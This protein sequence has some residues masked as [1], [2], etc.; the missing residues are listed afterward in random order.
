MSK[1]NRMSGQWMDGEL[2]TALTSDFLSLSSLLVSLC[3]FVRLSLS[4]LFFSTPF[5]SS[6]VFLL[7]NGQNDCV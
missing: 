2:K 7:L 6:V 5:P 4:P 3:L 1:L